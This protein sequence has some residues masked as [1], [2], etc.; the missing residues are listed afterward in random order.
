MYLP[1]SSAALLSSLSILAQYITNTLFLSLYSVASH[2]AEV[3]V[4]VQFSVWR[5]IATSLV[6][7]DVLNIAGHVTKKVV[8]KHL[9]QCAGSQETGER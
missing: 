2:V 5:L 9:A 4:L 1:H 6:T 3:S 7:T 8:M